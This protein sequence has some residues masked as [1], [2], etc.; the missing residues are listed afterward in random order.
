MITAIRNTVHGCGN[1]GEYEF[2][3]WCPVVSLP[4]L[5]SE[6]AWK[7]FLD[8]LLVHNRA[9]GWCGELW[10]GRQTSVSDGGQQSTN[11]MHSHVREYSFAYTEVIEGACL[12]SQGRYRS[13]TPKYGKQISWKA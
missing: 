1:A 12:I 8:T 7:A 10:L 5:Q 9:G 11:K 13:D 2:Y 4:H 6:I 3:L